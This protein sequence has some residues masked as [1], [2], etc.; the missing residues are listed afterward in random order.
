MDPWLE[1]VKAVKKI[2]QYSISKKITHYKKSS[3]VEIYSENYVNK[4]LDLHGFTQDQAFTM[5]KKFLKEAFDNNIKQVLVVTGKG[6]LDN[7]GVIK[8]VVPRWLQYTELNKYVLSYSAAK[9]SFGG[10]GAILISIK[11][12]AKL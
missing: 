7:P 5:L 2:K 1:Y 8:L 6:G 12:K 10:E 9:Q 4:K 3:H 11:N